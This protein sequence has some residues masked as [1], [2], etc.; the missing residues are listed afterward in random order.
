LVQSGGTLTETISGI[1]MYLRSEFLDKGYSDDKIKYFCM[2]TH[3]VFPMPANSSSFFADSKKVTKLITTKS[4][5][6]KVDQLV[7]DYPSKVEVIDLSQ[8]L[9]T[10]LTNQSPNPYVA[11]YSISI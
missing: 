7:R 10:V 1:D 3:S 8:I 11:P 5:P 4:R 9:W 2:V 6:L